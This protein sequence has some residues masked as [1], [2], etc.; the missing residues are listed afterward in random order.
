M[1]LCYLH[2]PHLHVAGHYFGKRDDFFKLDYH[3][4]TSAQVPP[5]HVLELRQFAVGIIQQIPPDGA[6]PRLQSLILLTVPSNLGLIK[7]TTYSNLC[8]L[9]LDVN[10]SVVFGLLDE[11]GQQLQSLKFR[12]CKKDTLDVGKVLVLCPRLK[13]FNTQCFSLTAVDPVIE[14][15]NENLQNLIV[16]KVH[17]AKK[18]Q[19]LP[20]ELLIQLMKAPLLYEFS[21]ENVRLG[22]E[23]AAL[24]L[25]AVQS[26][27]YL[28]KLEQF[29]WNNG[30]N[31]SA[32]LLTHRVRAFQI[33]YGKS[34]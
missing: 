20:I 9:I 34:A 22:A 11:L 31:D 21:I 15:P 12:L 3:N 26:G 32:Q 8:E 13:N 29:W 16:F 1:A 28:T 27:R 19:F 4:S 17:V 5:G 14:V 24:L 25:D 30:R 23:A 6:L 2:L 33:L 18:L 7:R 10:L